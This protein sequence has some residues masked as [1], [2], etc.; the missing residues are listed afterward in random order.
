MSI[1][2]N[3]EDAHNLH[4][5]MLIKYG[6][7]SAAVDSFKSAVRID[8]TL[9][10]AKKGLLEAMRSQYWLYPWISITNWRGR[11]VIFLIF[12][13]LIVVIKVTGKHKSRFC[14]RKMSIYLSTLELGIITIGVWACPQYGTIGALGYALTFLVLL[15]PAIIFSSDD[16]DNLF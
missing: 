8:P 2:P 5:Q 15:S 4:G 12:P 16:S 14:D 11:L 1:D 6:R 3:D 13:F 10:S 9:K 7:Y